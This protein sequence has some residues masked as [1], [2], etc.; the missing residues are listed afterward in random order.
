MGVAGE[1]RPGAARTRNNSQPGFSLCKL[2]NPKPSQT[3]SLRPS[4]PFSSH[5]TPRTH[6]PR[7]ISTPANS[8]TPACSRSALRCASPFHPHVIHSPP[9]PP[10]PGLRVTQQG[11]ACCAL[12]PNLLCISTPF[13]PLSF[14]HT[15]K[16]LATQG[17][18]LLQDGNITT[19]IDI[20]T[21]M[22]FWHT[23]FAGKLLLWGTARTPIAPTP[24]HRTQQQKLSAVPCHTAAQFH[25]HLC[26]A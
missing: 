13:A 24:H 14:S 26:S 2:H 7:D 19:N 1:L 9:P 15:R 22:F 3:L 11:E 16:M 12:H 6:S 8:Q 17:S 23:R 5:L 10:S 25:P 21:F 20:H 4:Q 18:K